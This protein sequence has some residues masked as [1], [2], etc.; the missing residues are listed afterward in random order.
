MIRSATRAL[1]KLFARSYDGGAGGRRWR[2]A[3][4]MPLTLAAQQAARGPLAKRARY[5]EANNGNAA[6]GVAAWASALTGS[7]IKPQ[8]AHPDAAVRSYLNTRFESWIERAD[9]DGITD[10]YGL[11]HLAARRMVI[12]GDSFAVM[13]TTPRGE[14]Q[15]KLMDPEQVDAARHQELPGG[16]ARLRHQIRRRRPAHRLSRL[17]RAARP[18][19]RRPARHRAPSRRRCLPPFQAADA[20]PGPRHFLVCPVLLRMREHDDAIDAQLSARKSPPCSPASL[21]IRPA[22]PRA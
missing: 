7:Q 11:Q 21:S 17:A 5:L 8:S 16:A 4:E 19:A 12:D 9:A 20:R 13:T 3:G 18:A 10:G 1:R 15:I 22:R 6:A 2:G 14:L